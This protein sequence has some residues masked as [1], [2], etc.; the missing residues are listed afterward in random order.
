MFVCIRAY[1]CALLMINKKHKP[2][3]N[4]SV[5]CAKNASGNWSSCMAFSNVVR[6]PPTLMNGHNMHVA[7]SFTTKCKCKSRSFSWF[8]I[9]PGAYHTFVVSS[10]QYRFS[11]GWRTRK[12][13]TSTSCAATSTRIQVIYMR[14][15]PVPMTV[16]VRS[17]SSIRLGDKLWS[18]EQDDRSNRKWSN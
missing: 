1:F 13:Y 7:A 6:Y 5:I 17:V 3:M 8:V 10:V 15:V 18:I 12:R 14:L 11:S 4:G 2:S 9:C 16:Y